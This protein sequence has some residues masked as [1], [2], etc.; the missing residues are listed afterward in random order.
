MNA[1]VEI[2]D[3]GDERAWCWSCRWS[4]GR[5][6]SGRASTFSVAADAVR[7]ALLRKYESDGLHAL[8]DNAEG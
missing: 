4:N 5:Y 3:S 2:F 7:M 1:E 6:D 8:Y